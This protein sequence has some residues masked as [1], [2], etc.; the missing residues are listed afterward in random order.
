[1]KNEVLDFL[2]N[3]GIWSIGP[4]EC[5]MDPATGDLIL[6]IKRDAPRRGPG[7]RGGPGGQPAPKPIKRPRPLAA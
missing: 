6:F 5:V 4:A 3:G 1:M 2:A 7:G